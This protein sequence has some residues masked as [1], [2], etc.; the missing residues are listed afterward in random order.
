MWAEFGFTHPG[1]VCPRVREVELLA[2]DRGAVEYQLDPADAPS[3][4][5]PA[6]V[7]YAIDRICRELGFGPD[8]P[9][10]PQRSWL[11]EIPVLVRERLAGVGFESLD[12]Y[13]EAR[14]E[15]LD[16]VTPLLDSVFSSG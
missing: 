12:S 10:S 16:A 7:V 6:S 9:E 14:K 3:A 8:E 13:V 5:L 1:A 4:P 2:R 15:Q 11:E